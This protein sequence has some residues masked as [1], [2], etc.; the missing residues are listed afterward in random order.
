MP[1]D[2]GHDVSALTAEQLQRAR[3]DLQVSLSLS[4]PGSAV[5]EPILAHLTAIDAELA[6]RSGWNYERHHEF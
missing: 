3:R 4:V 5:R 2:R 6:R 1:A